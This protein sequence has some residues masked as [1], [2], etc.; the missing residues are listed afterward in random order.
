MVHPGMQEDAE[1]IDR[2][3]AFG[4]IVTASDPV[5]K[6]IKANN[7]NGLAD[8]F[9]EIKESKYASQMREPLGQ[10]YSRGYH[11]P[12]ATQSNG[13]AFGV[14]SGKQMPAKELIYPAGGSQ[15]ERPE[16]AAMYAKTHGNIP[17]GTQKN[18]NYNWPVDVATHVFGYGEMRV[19]N[20][21]G[22]AIHAERI[23]DAFPKTVIV[24]KTVEDV[25]GTQNDLLGKSK[26]LG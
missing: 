23:D 4:K 11:M 26:N 12:E 14:A 19:P 20:G 15:E 17:A 13:F 22:S 3:R 21:A 9:N 10:S 5:S 6:V 18:R 1:N 7:L 8:K 25:K 2:N 24:E 16:T